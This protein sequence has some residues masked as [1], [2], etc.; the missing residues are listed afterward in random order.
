MPQT[1]AGW[2]YFL[3]VPLR[4]EAGAVPGSAFVVG[5]PSAGSGEMRVG[6]VNPGTNVCEDIS[7][8]SL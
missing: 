2:D 8:P 1:E 4:F 7:G 6:F 5:R 3:P